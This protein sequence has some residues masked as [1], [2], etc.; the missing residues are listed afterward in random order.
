MT[1]SIPTLLAWSLA[2]AGAEGLP[3][4]SLP[5]GMSTAP[6][7]GPA[8]L[9]G[10]E[11]TEPGSA[12]DVELRAASDGWEMLVHGPEGALRRAWLAVPASP[13]GRA[14]LTLL[15]SSL[16]ES[17]EV[18]L[19]A[20]RARPSLAA[21]AAMVAAAPSIEA[22]DSPDPPIQEEEPLGAQPPPL[23]EESAIAEERGADVAVA[24]PVPPPLPQTTTD[25]APPPLVE[26]VARAPASGPGAA[27]ETAPPPP[28]SA[29][30]DAEGDPAP[31]ETPA[32][33]EDNAQVPR[34]WSPWAALGLDASWRPDTPVSPGPQLSLGIRTDDHLSLGLFVS[35]G[36]HALAMLDGDKR[37]TDTELR[38]LLRW[39]G[40][41]W[42]L[43]PLAGLQL[44]L[45]SRSYRGPTRIVAEK[46]IPVVALELGACFESDAVGILPSLRAER[47]LVDTSLVE[48]GLTTEEE[49]LSPW[50]L[51]AGLSLV[52]TSLRK[53]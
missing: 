2:A 28:D 6:W 36:E 11:L 49:S 13:A 27:L 26:S 8:G 17:L 45:S 23:P 53:N 33:L 18:E 24:P 52:V 1:T 3:T 14:A 38:G 10:L 12:A 21:L 5:E 50:Q 48:I 40:G 43:H 16:L 29:T 34:H 15:A 41:P 9:A 46:T 51:E 31:T 25:P 19:P 37:F 42:R 20:P 7:N 4:L 22:L 32:I 30:T 44:G 35:R 39:A 47:D